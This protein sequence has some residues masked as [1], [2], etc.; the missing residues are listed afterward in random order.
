VWVVRFSALD[1]DKTSAY[2]CRADQHSILIFLHVQYTARPAA[3]PN[4]EPPYVHLGADLVG[5]VHNVCFSNNG[6]VVI[7]S[8]WPFAVS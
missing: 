5:S 3:Q 4:E 7:L 2:L 6:L 8:D 1:D